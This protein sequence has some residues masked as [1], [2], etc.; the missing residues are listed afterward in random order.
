MV[1]QLGTR[2]QRRATEKG[3]SAI[4]EP[5][6]YQYNSSDDLIFAAV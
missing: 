1:S 2:G 6:E 3:N 4:V 5:S